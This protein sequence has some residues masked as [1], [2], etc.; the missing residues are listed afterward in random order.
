MNVVA[1]RGGETD[2]HHQDSVARFSRAERLMLFAA[3][4]AKKPPRCCSFSDSV[5]A[6]LASVAES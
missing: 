3:V 5:G 2:L 4:E 1:G 6:D